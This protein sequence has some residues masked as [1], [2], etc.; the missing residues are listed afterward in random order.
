VGWGGVLHLI[1]FDLI[2]IPELNSFVSTMRH[3]TLKLF[4]RI[5]GCN[6]HFYNFFEL[7]CE[8]RYLSF[9]CLFL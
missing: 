3:M 1:L 2:F 9:L 4:S 8:V 6:R 5:P 7:D